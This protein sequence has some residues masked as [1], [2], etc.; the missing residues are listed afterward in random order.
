MAQQTLFHLHFNTPALETATAR[1]N[2]YGVPLQQRFGTVRGER[3][4]VGPETQ[5]PDEFRLKLQVH[6]IGAV[7]ISLAPGQQPHF[8]HLGVF[9]AD[10]D[11]VLT[12]ARSREWSVRSNE[13]RTFVMTPWGFRV[14]LHPKSGARGV[15]FGRSST[16]RLEDV[17]L[18]ASNPQVVREPLQTVFG[19]IPNLHLEA[20][21]KPWVSSFTVAGERTTETIPVT[22]LLTE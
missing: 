11:D 1:L 7:N 5:P 12:R 3:V 8:D 15:E 16:P 13:R 21:E 19:T 18:H 20:G 2:E 10:I 9:V 4:S 22:T 6:R 17:I 14:E